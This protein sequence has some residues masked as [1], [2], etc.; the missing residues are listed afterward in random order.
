MK[1]SRKSIFFS[2]MLFFSNPLSAQNG[3][4][5]SL[6]IY[7]S[8]DEIVTAGHFVNVIDE[9]MRASLSSGL[10]STLNILIRL[11]SMDN[12]QYRTVNEIIRLRYNVWEKVYDMSTSGQKKQFQSFTAIERFINDS[13][14]FRLGSVTGIPPQ[15]QLRIILTFSPEGISDSQKDRLN[16]WLLS[17]GEVKES[18]PAYDSES[19]FSINL[20][21]L[22]TAFFRKK[23]DRSV[24]IYK[25]RVFTLNS[26]RKDEDAS[27]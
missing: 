13:L 17:E 11:M 21:S 22:L 19:G 9:D 18:Q 8:G 2:L 27:R 15:K 24:Y 14:V 26:L 20:S 25:S 3:P 10:S 16:K 5:Q 6:E 4:V 23:E 7:L 12:T 1:I